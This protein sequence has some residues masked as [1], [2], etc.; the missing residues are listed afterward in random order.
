MY[1]EQ[2]HS[3]VVIDSKY[4]NDQ[5]AALQGQEPERFIHAEL[6]NQVEME[7]E[8]TYDTY[9]LVHDEYYR[10]WDEINPRNVDRI[11]DE[12]YMVCSHLVYA[13]VLNSRDWGEYVLTV[14]M[15]GC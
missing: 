13:F 3:R 4:Y 15:A 12:Q 11:S 5:Q 1:C 6:Q 2:I 9:A 7:N 14:A 10:K 8:N